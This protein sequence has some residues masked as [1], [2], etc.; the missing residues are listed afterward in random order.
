MEKSEKTTKTLKI[1]NKLEINKKKLFAAINKLKKSEL[2][3]LLEDSFDNMEGGT[4]RNVFGELFKEHTK[5]ERTPEKL[6]EEIEK[7]Y[8]KSKEGYYYA[9]FNVNSKNFSDIPEETDEWF[10]EIS[11]YLDFVSELVKEEQYKI[12]LKCFTLLFELIDKMEKGEEI[13]FADELGDWMISAK[14]D[15]MEKY[16]ITISKEIEEIEEYVNILIPR[17]KSDSYF[18]FSKKV[19][20]KVKKHSN[21]IQ[22]KAINKEIKLQSIRTK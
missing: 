16:I 19:Y 2:I 5:R 21:S 20:K 13:V 7:F 6:L 14:E 11:D 12:G 9:P 18:A 15:Y 8:N 3:S 10:D 22:L 4:Q 17:I 1:K